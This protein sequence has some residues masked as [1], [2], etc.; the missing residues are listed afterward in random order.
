ML[1]TTDGG[2][3]WITANG[4]PGSI[5]LDVSFYSPNDG[6]A[7]LPSGVVYGTSDGGA[8]WK[9]LAPPLAPGH[10]NTLFGGGGVAYAA[11]DASN[12][13]FRSED[14]GRSWQVMPNVQLREP[15][16]TPGGTTLFGSDPTCCGLYPALGESTD[17][18]VTWHA[19]SQ[20]LWFTPFLVSFPSDQVGYVIPTNS[21]RLYRTDNGGASFRLVAEVPQPI[22]ALDFVTAADG[23]AV[24]DGGMFYRITGGGTSWS[25]VSVPNLP[26]N[27]AMDVSFLNAQVG[28]ALFRRY[29]DGTTFLLVTTDG[30]LHWTA[31]S[32][33]L[34]NPNSVVV[35]GPQTA[36]L[37][38][39]R[40][41]LWT[42]DA[43]ASWAYVQ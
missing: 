16:S 7:L 27:R 15:D 43:G 24:T 35:T 14:G 37:S 42:D 28:M 33:P 22:G 10:A 21:Q 29:S 19:F 4:L 38:A 32:L 9:R 13:V 1:Q 12:R 2:R 18:G 40:G 26:P 34:T 36:L 17:G 3:N 5:V 39:G 25:V 41:L 23:W 11:S 8:D 30:G 31:R 6:I 20:P